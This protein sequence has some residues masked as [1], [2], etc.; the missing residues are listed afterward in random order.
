[1]AKPQK[2]LYIIT[3]IVMDGYTQDIFCHPFVSSSDEHLRSEL[4]RLHNKIEKE[5]KVNQQ[6]TWTLISD[7]MISA[8]TLNK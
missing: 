1:M 6:M 5:D 4:H 7:E 3:G 2:R 8:V